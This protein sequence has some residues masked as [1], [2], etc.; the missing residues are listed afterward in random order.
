MRTA[1]IL[2]ILALVFGF[3]LGSMPVVADGDA[4]CAQCAHDAD[5]DCG[6]D[7]DGICLA[8]AASCPLPA[9]VARHALPAAPATRADIAAWA[10][11]PP[12]SLALAPDTAP[13]KPSV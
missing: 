1:R 7:T 6:R 10:A 11:T 8:G 12:T 4:P 13:P 5:C 2:L 9:L 3:G